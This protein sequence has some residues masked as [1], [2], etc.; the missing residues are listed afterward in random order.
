MIFTAYMDEAD[1][2][3]PKPTIIMAAF[4][5]HAYQWRRFE[6]KLGRIQTRFG[7]KIFHAKDF[8]QKNGEFQGWSDDKCKALIDAL[9]QLVEENLTIGFAT[10]LERERYLA[11]YKAPPVPDRAPWRGV[12]LATSSRSPAGLAGFIRLPRRA[13]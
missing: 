3:G 7:F 11:E 2:H 1:T 10:H 8:K 13:A 6:I 12:G 5:G 4:L 9:T